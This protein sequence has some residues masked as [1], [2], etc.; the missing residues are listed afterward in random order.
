VGRTIVTVTAGLPGTA[1][2]LASLIAAHLQAG[3]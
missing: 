1:T 2:H 3:S